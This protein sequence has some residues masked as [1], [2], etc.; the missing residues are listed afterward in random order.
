M[1][2]TELEV[3]KKS[4]LLVK[5]IYDMTSSYPNSEMWGLAL[6]MRR[7]SVSIP[8]NLAEGCA[9]N[10]Q[11]ELLNFLNYSLGSL[12]ELETQIEISCM[13]KYIKEDVKLV[14]MQNTTLIRRMLLNLIKSIKSP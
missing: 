5:E 11:K 13:L 9:R 8:S 12:A 1:I 6:Q 7:A 14:Q 3:Y 10:S 2:H 4:L